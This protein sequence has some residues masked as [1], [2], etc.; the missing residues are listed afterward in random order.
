MDGAGRKLIIGCGYIGRRVAQAWVQQGAEVW[1]LTRSEEHARAL[2]DLG[3]RP[4]TGDVTDPSSLAVL[5]SAGTVLYSVGFD[6]TSGKTFREVYVDGLEHVLQALTGRT[7]RL[8]YISSTSVYGQNDGQWVDETS[9]CQPETPNGQACFDAEELVRR[10][11]GGQV[12]RLAGIYGPGRLMARIEALRAKE[13]L[14]GNPA[15]WLNLIH[16]DDAVAAILACELRGASGDTCLVCDDRP[17][18]RA[19][20]FETLARVLNLSLPRWS[21]EPLSDQERSKLNKRC[22]NRRLREQ[23]GMALRYPDIMQGLPHAC[24]S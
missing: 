11:A 20:Y 2:R 14:R 12:L 19:E 21:A 17:I 13:P 8:L 22:S 16:A 18:R 6:R 9:E 10:F 23:L 4:V 7:G 15:A 5:P 1:A 3:V 24:Q